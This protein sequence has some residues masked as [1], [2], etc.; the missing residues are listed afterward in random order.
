[1]TFFVALVLTYTVTLNA[2]EYDFKSTVIFPTQELCSQASDAI[3]PVIYHGFTRNSM[4]ACIKTDQLSGTERP[5][6][7]P[8]T[9]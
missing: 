4:A 2:E 8:W 5:R 3:Y 7:R 9:K 1:M 6:V